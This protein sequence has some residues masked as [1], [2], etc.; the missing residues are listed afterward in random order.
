M[1]NKP[2]FDGLFFMDFTACDSA[3]KNYNG[4]NKG[5]GLCETLWAQYAGRTASSQYH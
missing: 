5:G 1:N 3:K 2:S 4:D